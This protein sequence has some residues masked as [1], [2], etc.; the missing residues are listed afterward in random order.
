M[1]NFNNDDDVNNIMYGLKVLAR[2]NG[3]Q[4]PKRKHNDSWDNGKKPRYK[5]KRIRRADKW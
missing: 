2:R 1:D 5:E 4:K 3:Y